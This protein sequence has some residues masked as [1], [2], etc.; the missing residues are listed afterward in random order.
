MKTFHPLAIVAIV[1]NLLACNRGPSLEQQ[2][3]DKMN[4]IIQEQNAVGLSVAVVKDGKLIYAGSFGFKNLEESTLIRTDDLFRIASV[5]KSFTA[6]AIMQLYEQEKFDLDDDVSDAL[7]FWVRNPSYPDVPITYRML[8]SHRSSLNDIAG[9]FSFDVVDPQKNSE[10]RRAYNTY[11]P[12]TQ[13]EYCNLGYNM[14]GALVEIHSGE[15]FDRYIDHHIVKPLKLNGGFNVDEL[16]R[17]QFVTLYAFRNGEPVA[18]PEAYQS[19]AAGLE[20]YT[21]GR[22]AII[23]SPTGGMK[24]APKDLAKHMLVQMNGGVCDGVSILT[25]QSVA[26]MQTPYLSQTLT[27]AP[28]PTVVSS[29]SSGLLEG[30]S[31]GFALG[32]TDK[33]IQGE[34]LKGHTGSSYGLYSAMYFNPDKRYGMIMM[35]NGY[36]LQRDQDGFITIQVDVM[37][38]LHEIFIKEK[39]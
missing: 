18:S 37:R 22:S 26:L 10:Y 2:A 5:S 8:L 11:A 23:F 39:E 21:L 29:T 15:R 38:A 9:Y 7:D 27:F 6:T 30:D 19:R 16:D 3:S 12:G 33:L 17:G 24:I 1:G 25:P 32:A 35:T 34:T 36:P 31:Y 4:Q 20:N 14:L 13:Y 28:P